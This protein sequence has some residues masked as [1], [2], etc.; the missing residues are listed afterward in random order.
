MKMNLL[1]TTTALIITAFLLASS[2]QASESDRTNTASDSD[3][4][5]SFSVTTVDGQTISLEQS[6][7]DGKPVVVYFMAS[8]CSVCA[9][10]WPAISE[11]YP[12]YE[13]ELTFVAIS[14]DPTD[15][16]DVIRKLAKDRNFKFPVTAGMPQL[17]L[18]FGAT[19]QA[20]TVGIN[21]DGDIVFM[22]N[23]ENLSADEYRDLFTGLLN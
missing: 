10:N 12:E 13:E 5:P 22:K 3:K 23:K 8:W 14:I 9:R 15:T 1:K 2:V 19:T 16:A 21:R 4:A 6:L 20:T 11:A 17:M 7:E 18:D